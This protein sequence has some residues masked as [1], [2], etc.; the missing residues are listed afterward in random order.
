MG[1]Y[2]PVTLVIYRT[3]AIVWTIAWTISCIVFP[4]VCAPTW[5]ST[6]HYSTISWGNHNSWV[7]RR[8]NWALLVYS[9]CMGMRKGTVQGLNGKLLN[10]VEMCILVQDSSQ[11]QFLLPV[12][13]SCGVNGPLYY[14]RLLPSISFTWNRITFHPVTSVISF[15]VNNVM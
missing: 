1:L 11:S 13:V 2:G 10:H 12:P 3:I 8:C 6:T 7:N 9:H 5:Y 14:L 4:S 15:N